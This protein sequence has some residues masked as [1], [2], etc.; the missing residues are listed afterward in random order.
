MNGCSEANRVRIMSL[1]LHVLI[2]LPVINPLGN[3]SPLLLVFDPIQEGFRGDEEF[4]FFLQSTG[5]ST[6]SRFSLV[7]VAECKGVVSSEEISR[8]A[9]TSILTPVKGGSEEVSDI[10]CG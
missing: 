9:A 8:I 2:K 6:G 3:Q 5:V 1:F 10:V 4:E 7:V